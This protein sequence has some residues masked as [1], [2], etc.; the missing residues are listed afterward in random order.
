[1]SMI[2]V[3]NDNDVIIMIKVHNEN[4]HHNDNINGA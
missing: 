1:M 3:H 2:M 4:D